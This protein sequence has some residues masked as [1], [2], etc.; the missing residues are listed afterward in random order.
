M[1]L[2]YA[3][4]GIFMFLLL[5]AFAAAAIVMLSGCKKQPKKDYNQAAIEQVNTRWVDS[6]KKRVDVAEIRIKAKLDSI[7]LNVNKQQEIISSFKPVYEKVYTT[8]D[9]DQLNL[10]YEL[11]S[12][13]RGTPLQRD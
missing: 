3:V 13:H 8:A 7:Q 4:Y 2:F 11:L 1:R 5:L 6:L 9:A 12:K 10:T